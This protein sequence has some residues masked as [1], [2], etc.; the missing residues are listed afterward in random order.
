VQSEGKRLYDEALASEVRQGRYLSPQERWD[1]VHAMPEGQEYDRLC[2]L[3]SAHL[4]KMEEM[5]RTMWVTPART[6]EGRRAK[7]L[8]L[9][10]CVMSR[11]WS[12]IEADWGVKEAATCLSSL[13]AGSLPNN[14][15]ISFGPNPEPS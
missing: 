10:G 5:I 11:D 12:D 6:P 8:V 9:L 14:C 2:E 1:R 4:M 13:S 15:A 3:Q 7:V